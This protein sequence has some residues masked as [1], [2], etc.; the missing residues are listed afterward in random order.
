MFNSGKSNVT[1]NS[2]SIVSTEGMSLYAIA[3][4]EPVTT[5]RRCAAMR[6]L[7]ASIDNGVLGTHEP[8]AGA[9]AAL[10][11]RRKSWSIDRREGPASCISK[12]GE[13]MNE[14]QN[15]HDP[16]VGRGATGAVRIIVEP[17]KH[18]RLAVGAVT[19][20][21]MSLDPGGIERKNNGAVDLHARTHAWRITER[22]P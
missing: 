7:A 20:V 17:P 11:R 6:S 12:G 18:L 1:I 13:V 4:T 9:S 22:N 8:S 19:R 16:R 15:G 2:R 3:S 10:D 5:K 21:A 14:E